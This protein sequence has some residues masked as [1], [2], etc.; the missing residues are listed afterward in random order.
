[1]SSDP[2]LPARSSRGWVTPVVGSPWRAGRDLALVGA[3]TGALAPAL[4]VFDLAFC[5]AAGAAGALGGLAIGL[6]GAPLVAAL[7]RQ[8]PLPVLL[9]AAP[10]TGAAWGGLAGLAGGLVSD[11]G[12]GGGA[13]LFALLAGSVAGSLQLSALSL[14][15]LVQ[16][17]RDAPRWPVVAA[18]CLAAPVLGWVAVVAG[19]VA[20]SPLLLP[21][22][23]LSLPALV[24]AGIL[25]DR[26]TRSTGDIDG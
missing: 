23:L 10:V 1:M 15:Y 19:A 21:V 5:L 8:L 6:A 14:P 4:V 17:V 9:C 3:V 25:L 7:R 24:W 11:A 20:F 16:S 18:A 22:V 2:Q 26:Q 12:F 13:W